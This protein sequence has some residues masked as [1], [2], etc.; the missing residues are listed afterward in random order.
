M[1]MYG[2]DKMANAFA[3]FT[4]GGETG[5]VRCTKCVKSLDEVA[6]EWIEEDDDFRVVL[7]RPVDWNEGASGSDSVISRTTQETAQQTTRETLKKSRDRNGDKSRDRRDDNLVQKTTAARLLVHVTA[8]PKEY[9][10]GLIADV[11]ICQK[12]VA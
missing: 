4:Q 6:P 11:V 2:L 9:K 10:Q 7:R 5:E 8:A 1:K 12:R 3:D